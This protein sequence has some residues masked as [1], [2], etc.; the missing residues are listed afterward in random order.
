MRRNN[1]IVFFLTKILFYICIVIVTSTLKIPSSLCAEPLISVEIF[2]KEIQ[3]NQVNIESPVIIQPLNKVLE[4]KQ[5]WKIKISRNKVFLETN[6]NLKISTG[7]Q[8]L[9][10]IPEEKDYLCISTPKISKRC[11]HGKI[12]IKPEK[13]KLRLINNVSITDYLYSTIGSELPIKWP[14]EA[15]KAQT[16]VIHSYL[17]Y[18]IKK[19]KLLQDSTQNQFYGGIAYEKPEYNTYINE[20]KDI[21]ITD[22]NGQPVEALYH[23]TCAGKTL[24]NEEVFGGKAKEYLRGTPC[25]YDKESNFSRPKTINIEEYKLKK[26]LKAKDIKFI[27]DQNGT[28]K[29]IILNNKTLSPYEFWLKLGKNFGWGNIPGIKYNINCL[30]N[31]CSTTSIGAGHAVGL[32]QWGARGMAKKGFNYQEI[33]RYYYKKVSFKGRNS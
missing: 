9:I 24:N 19:N 15:V 22:Q 29:S 10:L 33:L 27:K 3:L 11:Y 1:T 26:T 25:P 5:H 6:N 21:I 30:K 14:E 31:R 4:P 32:C 28:L 2:A 13:N 7:N 18:T 17:L 16:V 8:N 20:V 12:Q 23:S